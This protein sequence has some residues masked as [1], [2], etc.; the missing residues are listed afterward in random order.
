MVASEEADVDVAA[1]L[2]IE[3]ESLEMSVV[4][5]SRQS[6]GLGK[7]AHMVSILDDG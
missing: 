4:V 3:S 5:R 1:L 2:L 7:V 6:W